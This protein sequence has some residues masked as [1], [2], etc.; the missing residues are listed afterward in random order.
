M[1]SSEGSAVHEIDSLNMMGYVEVYCCAQFLDVHTLRIY[2][3]L[4]RFVY[5]IGVTCPKD[6]K[7]NVNGGKR[8]KKVWSGITL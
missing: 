5:L 8:M 2:Q 3:I 1:C 7:L 4:I 6:L